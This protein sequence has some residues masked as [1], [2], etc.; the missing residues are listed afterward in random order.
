MT[1]ESPKML[2]NGLPNINRYITTHN[3]E[4]KATL[5]DHISPESQWQPIG[6][7]ANFF[8][9][10]STRTFPVSLSSPPS[11]SSA[12]SIPTDIA[13]Y[14]RDLTSPPG[15]SISTGTV[16]RYVD[17]QPN[18]DSPMHK[19]A[20][21][22]YGVVLEGVVEMGLDSGETK[23]MHRG[24]VCV[25]RATNHK[26]RNVTPNDGWARMLFV[27]IAA[28]QVEGVKE[29]LNGTLALRTNGK[30]HKSAEAMRLKIQKNRKF[31]LADEKLLYDILIA[32]NL[33]QVEDK[34]IFSTLIE[35]VIDVF[36]EA[37]CQ[38]HYRFN[39]MSLQCYREV[40]QYASEGATSLT[41][42]K[43]RKGFIYTREAF[44]RRFPP[45]H[46]SSPMP[47][48][49]TDPM[50]SCSHKHTRSPNAEEKKTSNI[51][52]A[53][54]H[55]DGGVGGVEHLVHA[56][57]RYKYT[58]VHL[59]CGLLLDNHPTTPPED[60][61]TTM[62][63]QA[64]QDPQSTSPPPPYNLAAASSFL[65]KHKTMNNPAA[66]DQGEPATSSQ[67]AASTASPSNMEGR[68]PGGHPDYRQDVEHGNAGFSFS[69]TGHRFSV[70]WSTLSVC[71]LVCLPILF[72][73]VVIAVTL[74]F[75]AYF[76]RPT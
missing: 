22:D 7:V 38:G 41:L 69:S 9:G 45:C 43:V 13:S 25:Q 50:L 63:N 6:S 8:V 12:P 16:L 3:K 34:L 17:F 20:S 56:D 59:P 23:I 76:R 55:G 39:M 66:N 40:R 47:Q 49:P 28:E 37:Y 57:L 21:I 27:L 42:R 19:T 11:T 72:I 71:V 58:R 44:G 46:S 70:H 64:D 75:L 4:G 15:L 51:S 14:R 10:Y 31:Q 52:E 74:V 60:S 1:L 73:V 30:L 68:N 61:P 62:D 53:G 5:S 35:G 32:S 26:W 36:L 24:D 18:T 2:E 29:E 33:E 65:D 54:I 48:L 67:H